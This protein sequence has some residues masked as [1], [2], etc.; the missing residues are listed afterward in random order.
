MLRSKHSDL[1]ILIWDKQQTFDLD[2]IYADTVSI[3]FLSNM[4]Y[5]NLI[6]PLQR[7]SD[8]FQI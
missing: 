8:L 6:W 3:L 7:E 5:F 4:I 1:I 2:L